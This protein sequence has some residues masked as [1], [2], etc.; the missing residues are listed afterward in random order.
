MNTVRPEL[1]RFIQNP[2]V[3]HKVLVVVL[4]GVGSTSLDTSLTAALDAQLGVLPETPFRQGNA[5]AAAYL[6][7]LQGLTRLTTYRTLRAHGPSVGLPSKDDMGNSEVGHNALG[8]GRVFAQ[9]AKLV[10][11]AIASGAI[12][13][14][15]GWAKVARRPELASGTATLHFCGL[16]SDGNVHSHID[17]LLALVARARAEGVRRVRI[18]PLLD[19]RDVPPTSAL[20]YV[21]RLEAFLASLRTPEFDVKVASGGG[22][23]FVTMD[24]Y[25]ADWRIVERGYAAHVRGDARAFP[26]LREA[27]ETLRA[28]TKLGDQDLPPFVVAE[29][30]LPVGTVKDGDSFVFLNFRGDR[31]IQ[32]TRALT[33]ATFT[34]FDRVR[35]PRVVFAGMMQYDGDLKLPETYLVEPPAIAGTMGEWL[36][37]TGVTQFACSETQKFGHVTFF[38]NGNRSGKFDADKETYVEIP[39]DRVPFQQRPWMKAAEIA[40]ATID[41]MRAD[42]FRVGRINFAN[43]DMVGHTGDFPAACVAMGAVDLA[44]GRI[45]DAALETGTVVIVTSDHGNA[46]EMYEL[47]KKTGRVALDAS[48]KPKLKTSHT[49]APVPFA[50]HNLEALGGAALSVSLRDD[51]PEAGLANVAATV[52][53]LAGYV[54]PAGFE[55]SLLTWQGPSSP[56]TGEKKSAAA[57]GHGPSDRSPADRDV[58]LGASFALAR[59][60]VAFHR[61]VARL[62]SPDGGC[63][64]DREQTFESLRAFLI[65]ES[66]EAAH[67]ARDAASAPEAFADELGDVLLQVFLNAQ[68]AADDNL[69]EART[70]FE[71]I[72]AKMI[73]RHP[74]VFG[75]KSANGDVTRAGTT[76]E[77]AEEVVS[78]WDAIKSAEKAL[79][80]S[81]AK[82]KSL[83]HKALKKRGLPTLEWLREVSR[84]SY[85]M[86]FAWKTLPE[87][88]GDLRAEV[89]ELSEELAKPEFDRDRVADEM[90]DVAYALAN[91]ATWLNENRFPE[92]RSIDLDLAARDAGEKFVTRFAEMEAI[93]REGGHPLDETSAQALS[94]DAWNEL[95]TSAKR[96]RYR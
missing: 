69:F 29:A 36:A 80:P 82:P 76:V 50:I 49:L 2:S 65:E 64:W 53:E 34:A 19:G 41:A 42:A 61:T 72:D 1:S 27:V 30:G 40:D 84:R 66:Y 78:Q 59:A 11:E 48:G 24:R 77:T 52:L 39:S 81:E 18:H 94:L 95:W 25:E 71:A 86:G 54:P 4:D 8:A 14:G 6:P 85:K 60:A 83:L 55:P 28:E 90:G 43:G 23:S 62:R 10:N 93:R 7:R 87:T 13:E 37:R 73:R 79:S 31:A 3:A 20:E 46:D 33:E 22:R 57:P 89:D 74:H 70:V 92:P 35:A 91:V 32:I 38:W 17:H 16:L 96:R 26:S 9:G 15:S 75:V 44:L 21:D 45:L 88:F 58:S 68:L 51:L 67:A 12:F 56:G 5:V 47:E 63:P